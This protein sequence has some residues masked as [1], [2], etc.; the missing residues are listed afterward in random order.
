MSDPEQ[1]SGLAQHVFREQTIYIK[2]VT[3]NIISLVVNEY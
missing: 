2:L 1:C 3:I